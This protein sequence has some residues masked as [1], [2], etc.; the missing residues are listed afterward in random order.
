MIRAIDTTVQKRTVID[1]TLRE[2]ALILGFKISACLYRNV[3]NF[4]SA[5]IAALM[6]TYAFNTIN[7]CYLHEPK[8]VEKGFPTFFHRKFPLS[9][10]RRKEI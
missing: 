2:I 7:M 4:L 8:N 1:E 10:N 9:I 3:P 5:D 6:N